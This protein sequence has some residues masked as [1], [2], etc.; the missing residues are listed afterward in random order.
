MKL[1]KNYLPEHQRNQIY[2]WI[3]THEYLDDDDNGKRCFAVTYKK[4]DLPDF[5]KFVIKENFNVYNFIGFYT[6]KNGYIEPHVD[7]DLCDRIQGKEIPNIPE[8]FFISLPET[9]VYYADICSKM[10]G[11]EIVVDGVSYAPKT[12]SSI[13]LPRNK[14]HSV[15]A[16][17]HQEKLR[18]TLVCEKY[19]IL[20]KYLKTLQ[21]P[22][23]HK[24]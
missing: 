17:T 9:E 12:N 3:H 2:N 8:D 19:F 5:L 15:N 4:E 10:E 24:G 13:T 7:R 11:G 16:I 1:E 21:T 14:E 18:T 20:K 23:F 22:L 6:L